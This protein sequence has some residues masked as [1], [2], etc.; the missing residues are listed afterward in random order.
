MVKI[1]ETADK[2]TLVWSVKKVGDALRMLKGDL[3]SLGVVDREHVQLLII[4]MDNLFNS[5]IDACET[6]RNIRKE[7][8]MKNGS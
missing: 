1:K 4:T 3:K 6:V 5:I 7:E 8:K 2:Y